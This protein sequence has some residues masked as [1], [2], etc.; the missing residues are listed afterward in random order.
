MDA[1]FDA[2]VVG[3]RCAGSP[4]ATLLARAG[5]SVALVDRAEFPSDTL[6]THIF[7]NEGVSVLDRLGVLEEVLAS[8]APWLERS[9]S[10]IDRLRVDEPVPR[11]PGDPGPWLCVR[12]PV[13]DT[14]LVDA[15]RRAG[16]DVRTGTRVVGLVEDGG[17]VG[18][19]RVRGGEGDGVL[20]APLVVGADGRGSVVARTARARSYNLIP[21]ERFGLWGYYE[22]ARTTTPAR[23][24]FQRWDDELVLASPTDSGLFMVG[25]IPPLERLGDFRA[26]PEGFFDDHVAR[27]E[28]V[29]D[30][31]A[32]AT[33]AGDLFAML[34]WTGYFRESAGPGWALVG[35]AGHFKD[36]TP[37][38]G[39]SDALRQADR[40]APAI[41][42]GL[43]GGTPLDQAMAAWWRWRDDDAAEMAWFAGDLGKAGPVPPVLVEMLG[44]VVA[45]GEAASFLDV[46][47]HRTRPSE[48]LTP[49]RLAA[50]TAR[51]L[52]RRE[53]KRSQIL[54]Q[55]KDMMAEEVRRQRLNKHPAYA[56]SGA[57]VGAAT[58]P[59]EGE[60]RSA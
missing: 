51:L 43:G 2:V 17:R 20:T 37:G 35:D 7:Q 13:L 18:G 12:R 16:A 49:T 41:V 59:A 28:P 3:A 33:R 48:V 31:L 9:E 50:A 15:A 45:K 25:V 34:R 36:P 4:L 52:K 42:A 47:N 57:H 21:N 5:M 10:R 1:A 40:L 56:D 32:G 22:G 23:I 38:Q 30:V 58:E 46:F 54:R 39:I 29:A 6:S 44:D 24:Y 26:D 60:V 55:T 53:H 14:I 27:C 11:R 8:G 19:V